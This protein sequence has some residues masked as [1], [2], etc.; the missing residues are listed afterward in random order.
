VELAKRLGVRGI[1]IFKLDGG[2]DP[3]I[4]NVLTGIKK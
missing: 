3:D 4:W 1:S 2:Q